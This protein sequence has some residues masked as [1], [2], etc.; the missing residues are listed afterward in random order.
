MKREWN[1]P[2]MTILTFDKT[3]LGNDPVGEVDDVIVWHGH[4]YYSFSDPS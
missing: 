1:A 3:E 4:T 2:Q